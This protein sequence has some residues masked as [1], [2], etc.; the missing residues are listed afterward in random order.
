MEHDERS[1]PSIETKWN[2]IANHIGRFASLRYGV[3]IVLLIETKG[4]VSFLFAIVIDRT[5]AV[6]PTPPFPV[7]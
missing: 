1:L 5:N 4:Y 6:F 2:A 3:T 7:I